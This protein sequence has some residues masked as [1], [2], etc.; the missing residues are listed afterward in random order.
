MRFRCRLHRE[1]SNGFKTAVSASSSLTHT[2][3]E[4]YISQNR[5]NTA[6]ILM[7]ITSFWFEGVNKFSS[8]IWAQHANHANYEREIMCCWRLQPPWDVGATVSRGLDLKTHRGEKS[9]NRW[10]GSGWISLS[11][12]LRTGQDRTGQAYIL[13]VKKLAESTFHPKNCREKCKN[14]N[15]KFLGQMYVNHENASNFVVK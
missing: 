13:K 10:R 14:C 8:Y 5:R 9:T 6:W 3:S 15:N 2:D 7:T 4:K 12:F 11:I 1:A